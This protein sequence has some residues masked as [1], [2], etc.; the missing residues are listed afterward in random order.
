MTVIYLLHITSLFSCLQFSL[1]NVHDWGLLYFQSDHSGNTPSLFIRSDVCSR[2][3][4]FLP[5]YITSYRFLDNSTIGNYS[6]NQRTVFPVIKTVDPTNNSAVLLW[7]TDSAQYKGKPTC[8]AK[9]LIDCKLGKENLIDVLGSSILPL[10]TGKSDSEKSAF[11]VSS[12]EIDPALFITGID[13]IGR[14]KCNNQDGC[15]PMFQYNDKFRRCF[16]SCR[17]VDHQT[18]QVKA[19]KCKKALEGM[20]FHC[21]INSF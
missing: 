19:G 8:G 1:A 16:V 5:S 13:S 9:Q 3:G 18:A 14:K 20:F 17:F 7:P 2:Q 4:S 6:F 21:C 11:I 15:V 12:S 10:V